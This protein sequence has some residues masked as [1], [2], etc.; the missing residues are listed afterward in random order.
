MIRVFKGKSPAHHPVSTGYLIDGKVAID[1]PEGIIY[2]NPELIILTHEH[3]D[4]ITGIPN[5]SCGIAASPVAIKEIS[6]GHSFCKELG[7]PEIKNAEIRALKGNE[8]LKFPGFTLRI[9]HTP[10]HCPGAI[11]IYLEEK[12][13]LFSGDTVFPDL[14]LPN[15]SLPR[16]D[17]AQLLNSYEKLSGLEIGKFFPG[18]GEPFSAPGYMEKLK[19]KLTML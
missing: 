19:E 17:P 3:C 18:H 14:M 4:H 11:C 1:A 6:I 5:H 13:Y 2:P 15:L 7:L 16:S 9:L 12:K 8:L 10:G